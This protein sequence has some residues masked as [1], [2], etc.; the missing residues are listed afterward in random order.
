MCISFNQIE[1]I[2]LC[3]LFGEFVILNAMGTLETR[4]NLLNL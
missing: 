1:Y 3:C 4:L 2:D